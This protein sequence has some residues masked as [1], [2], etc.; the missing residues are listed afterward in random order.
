MES[1]ATSQNEGTAEQLIFTMEDKDHYVKAFIAENCSKEQLAL[2]KYLAKPQKSG[3]IDNLWSNANF[4]HSTRIKFIYEEYFDFRLRNEEEMLTPLE[5][6]IHSKE[7]RSRK[8]TKT[9]EGGVVD[10]YRFSP[11]EEECLK[12]LGIG[13]SYMIQVLEKGMRG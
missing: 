1:L 7:A 6:F 4:T 13:S 5:F 10:F 12:K 2:L 3:K 8:E 11:T 9:N